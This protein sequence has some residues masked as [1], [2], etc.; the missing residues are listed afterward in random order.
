M[1]KRLRKRFIRITMIAVACVMAALALIVSTANFIS[2]NTQLN[3]ML[4]TISDNQGRLP[5]MPPMGSDK[6]DKGGAG[7]FTAET[8]FSTRYF[9]LR[10]TS[11]GSLIKADLDNIAAVTEDDVQTYVDIAVKHGEGYGY[12]PGYKYRVTDDGS[13]RRMAIFL[14]CHTEIGGAVTV[15]L[16]S[17]VAAVFCIAVVYVIVVLCSRRAIDPVVKASERPKQFI[18]DAGHELK[19]PI[20][21]I[22]TSL[23]VLEM[24]TG[25][26]KWIDKAQAQTEKLTELVN[27]LVTLSR[28][29]EEESPLKREKFNISDSVAETANSFADF[30]AAAGH[31]LE[32]SVQPDIEYVGDEYAVRQLASILLD[33]A[34]K[35]AADGTTIRFSLA[36]ERRGVEMRCSNECD[37][38]DTA[39]L[40][41]LF[42]RFY[43]ADKSRSSGGF[44]I[45]LSIARSIAEGHKGSIKAVS[46][47]ARTI[48][49][50]AELK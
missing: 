25:K 1:I 4:K 14:D 48:E 43:R 9:V 13:G 27:S 10:Y 2:V 3:D 16:L 31:A 15:A 49:F 30:A 23:K 12:C 45:G 36:K 6:P 11:D 38:L 33:N 39:E 18:T 22:A 50:I 7:R 21:V 34:V 37:G 47:D 28:M 26:Q 5:P 35:Y 41:R 17:L 19:T 29:D 24:E 20:T 46:P 32:V 42:D 44:G 8:P 40:D